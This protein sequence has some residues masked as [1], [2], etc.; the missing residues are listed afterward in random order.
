MRNKSD[1]FMRKIPAKHQKWLIQELPILEDEGILTAESRNRLERYYLNKVTTRGHWATI[2]LGVLGALLIGGGIILLFAH[3]WENLSRSG[4]AI[5]SFCPLMLAAALSALAI[6]RGGTSLRESAGIFHSLAVG[7]CIAL[8]GQTYHLPSNTPAFLLTWAL[9]LMPLIFLL[10]SNGA[11]LFYIVL[12][13]CWSGAAQ[14][15]YGQALGFWLLLIP[16]LIYVIQQIRTNYQ[17]GLLALWGLM[18]MLPIALGM[19]LERTI[20]G[21]WII[22]YASF[23]SLAGLLGMRHFPTAYGWSNPLRTIGL[24]G[25]TALAY[26]CTWQEIWYDIGWGYTRVNFTHQESGLWIDPALTAGLA[27][28]WAFVAAKTLRRDCLPTLVLCAFP[29]CVCA[30]FLLAAYGESAWINALLFNAFVLAL[31]LA[32][33]VQ[34]CKTAQL[35][36]VN[37]GMAVLSLLLIT[38]FFDSEFGFLTRG[39]AFIF[40]GSFF[41]ATNLIIARKKRQLESSPS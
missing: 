24:N 16:A 36:Q 22:A 5:L 28:A 37:Y 13:C 39:L 12:I 38:R 4:R 30:G 33:L 40:M 41:L 21:L 29:L 1:S 8:I 31:G 9:L 34:G 23:L 27:T 14:D 3:N 18:L 26:I 10:P 7:A 32:H 2:A 20:P 35:R 25:V 15:Q 19:V 6:R 17:S 11:Y